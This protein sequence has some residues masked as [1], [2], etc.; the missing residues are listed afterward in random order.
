MNIEKM[1]KFIQLAEEL[2]SDGVLS[3]N[4]SSNQFHVRSKELMN[5][6]ELKIKDRGDGTYPYEIY[7]E[8]DDFKLFALVKTEDLKFLPQFKEFA[9]ANLRKQLEELEKEEEVS[10]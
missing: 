8:H 6:K 4:F 10:A 7:V 2:K 1:K 3:F 5:E 9:K